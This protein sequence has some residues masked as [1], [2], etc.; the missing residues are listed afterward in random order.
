MRFA[1][2]TL[3]SAKHSLASIGATRYWLLK[4]DFLKLYSLLEHTC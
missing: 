3:L 4:D 2:V 1:G